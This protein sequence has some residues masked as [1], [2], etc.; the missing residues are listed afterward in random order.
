MNIAD[1]PK[2]K[3]INDDIAAGRFYES[4]QHV[5]S[6]TKR[7]VIAK[8]FDEVFEV[9]HHFAMI[10]MDAGEHNQSIE[11]MKEYINIAKRSNVVLGTANEEHF[12]SFYNATVAAVNKAMESCA[13]PSVEEAFSQVSNILDLAVDMMESP[14]LYLCLGKHC[15]DC[16]Q[17]LLAQKYLVHGQDVELLFSA[18]KKWEPHVKEHERGLLYLR[19]ILVLLAIGD[20]SSA[21]C[22]MLML[23]LDVENAE[24]LPLPLQLAY[25]LTELC[26]QPDYQLFK[27]TCKTYRPVIDADPNLPRLMRKFRG[28][29]FPDIHDPTDPYYVDPSMAG[30]SDNPMASLLKSLM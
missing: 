28:R 12:L 18:L 19:C 2:Y 16:N 3:R 23:D 5:M 7:M 24:V 20:F 1:N 9:L 14:K 11:L 29:L 27:V 30:M 22:M 10:Y 21:K 17:L 25:I 6:T 8:R 13:G 4:L 15:I 26:E